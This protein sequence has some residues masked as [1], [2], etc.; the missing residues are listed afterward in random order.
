[1]KLKPSVI[2]FLGAFF[3]FGMGFMLGFWYGYSAMQDQI[4][5][6]HAKHPDGDVCGNSA[7]MLFMPIGYGLFFGA[8]GGLSGAGI[9]T[10]LNQ[11]LNSTESA[12]Y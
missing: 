5:A 6:I 4:D 7:I 8:I 2:L 3:G 12:Q 11:R 1:M 9:S 10:I